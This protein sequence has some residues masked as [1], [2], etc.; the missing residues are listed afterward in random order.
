VSQV[1]LVNELAVETNQAS[2][3]LNDLRA[4]NHTNIHTHGLHVDPAV[5]NAML[6]VAPGASR[7][8]K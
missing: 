5:D 8:Y 4:P 1:T 2:K 7:T 6:G 3:G